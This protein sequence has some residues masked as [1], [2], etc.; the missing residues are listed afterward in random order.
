MIDCNEG[1]RTAV[2]LVFASF[3]RS[4]MFL[5][6]GIG[7]GFLPRRNFVYTY[8]KKPL[9]LTPHLFGKWV[10]RGGSFTRVGTC[11]SLFSAF[12]VCSMLA[13]DVKYLAN[14]K[15]LYPRCTTDIFLISDIEFGG[16]NLS[17]RPERPIPIS[18]SRR[19]LLP[20]SLPSASPIAPTHPREDLR[21]VMIRRN[22]NDFT[23]IPSP[24]KHLLLNLRFMQ[25]YPPRY[26]PKPADQRYLAF[27]SKHISNITSNDILTSSK[28]TSVRYPLFFLA[29]CSFFSA[30]DRYRSVHFRCNSW[31]PSASSGST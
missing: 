4:A 22:F 21:V 9:W 17:P 6:I 13:V 27:L 16:L 7:L 18:N 24:I 23:T 12:V 8:I 1:N 10:A 14:Q 3:L 31:A 20:T 19:Q 30:S 26:Q 5:S 29:V 25:Q 2:I 28:F 15:A 11:I